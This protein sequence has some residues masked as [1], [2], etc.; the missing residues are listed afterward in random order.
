MERESE[1]ISRRNKHKYI[2]CQQ[3]GETPAERDVE[4]KAEESPKKGE[5]V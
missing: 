2:G 5:M 4:R 3:D 1:N